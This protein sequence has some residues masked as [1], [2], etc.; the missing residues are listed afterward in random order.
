MV[1]SEMLKK[2]LLCVLLTFG[3]ESIAQKDYTGFVRAVYN[4]DESTA[5]SI[6]D[7]SPESPDGKYICYIRYPA[8]AQGGHLAPP[9][10]AEVMLKNRQTEVVTKIKDVTCNNHNG[11]NALWIND[12]LVAFQESH[13]K[14]FEVYNV[15]SQKSVFGKIAGE[16]GHKS[17]G[18]VLFYSKCNARL[19]IPDQS[20]TPYD[21]DEEGIYVFDCLSG[22]STQIIQQSEIIAAF[23]KQN[24]KVS[25]YETKILHLEPN[26]L[27]DKIMFDYRYRSDSNDSWHELHGIISADGSNPT[28]IK[29]RPMHVVWFDNTSM[30][31]VGTEDPENRIFC[32]DLYGQK[33]EL[34][35]G[36]STHVGMSPNKKWYIGESDFYRP[37]ADGFTRVYLY[38]RGETRPYALLAQWKNAKIT[39]EWVAHVNPSFSF[40]G[41]RAYFIRAIDDEDKFESVII[42][43]PEFE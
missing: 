24:K 26:V 18:N 34:L 41:K 38:K 4:G 9:V 25:D 13:F 12:S 30:L 7:T 23:M 5:L 28:W 2:A 16:L 17:F 39:W 20:R 32:Y 42:Q 40:D 29:V 8:I 21:L 3:F 11:A 37:E 1:S 43:L 15:N 19:L 27:N 22:N 14:D 36:T 31:G 6:Y 10:R 33:K 35:G